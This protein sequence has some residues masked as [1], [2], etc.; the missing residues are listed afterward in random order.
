MV[1][2]LNQESPRLA[3]SSKEDDA[4]KH[5]KGT[6]MG[7]MLSTLN[8][9]ERLKSNTILVKTQIYYKNGKHMPGLLRPQQKNF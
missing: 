2:V 8:S 5:F 4:R 9:L 7:K 1:G 3:P 6:R